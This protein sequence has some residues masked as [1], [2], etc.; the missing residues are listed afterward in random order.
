MFHSGQITYNITPSD[1]GLECTASLRSAA[2]EL[3]GT[4][5]GCQQNL[6]VDDANLWWPYLM[7]QNPGY[8]YTLTVSFGIF[9]D[10]VFVNYITIK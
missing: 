4:Q 2:G 5:N 3:V 6:A 10:L 1:L 8:L 7:H 9:F